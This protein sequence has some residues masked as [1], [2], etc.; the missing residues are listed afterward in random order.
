MRATTAEADAVV[1]GGGFYGSTIAAYLAQRGLQRVVL[2]EREDDLFARASWNNQARVHNGYHYPRS[3]T[4]AWRSRLNM[5][6]FVARWPEAVR[7]DFVKLYAVAARDSHIT[8]GQFERFCH[9][10]GAPAR[11]ADSAWR[12]LF[13]PRRIE[14][15]W[16]VEEYA[17][18]ASYLRQW[19]R[20]ELTALGVQLL[21]RSRVTEA[22]PDG[23]GYLGI[24]LHGP[25]GP[26]R[27][28]SQLL[29][30]CTYSGLN[31]LG[32]S[33]PGSVTQLRH[34]LTEMA[35]V[36]VPP[37]L[38]Q[39]GITVMD[40]P[41]FSMM[42]FPSRS[43]HTLS[44]VRYTPHRS[45]LDRAGDDPY[46]Q[47]RWN[48]ADSRFDRMMRDARRY[49]PLAAEMRQHG[50]LVEIKTVLLRNEGDDG[51]PILFERHPELPGCYSILGGKID[52]IFDVLE[53]LDAEHLPG[54]RPHSL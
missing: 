1:V 35:L 17:F 14:Q 8:A 29:M 37:A 50:S 48:P 43:L 18:D 31:Q 51:R 54:V 11:R 16:E 30:N 19:A 52:N 44:H 49:L 38:R 10:I 20:A 36:E 47:L 7:R 26:Q 33:F 6:R 46:A 15:V 27:L 4:T 34:E 42:P 24:T 23:N 22:A 45:W 13:D 12:G 39:T 53:K 25:A 21:L 28:R 40:G 41:F 2:V 5:P 32:G 9:H 3:L